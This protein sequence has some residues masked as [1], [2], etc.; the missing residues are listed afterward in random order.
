MRLFFLLVI[1]LSLVFVSDYRNNLDRALPLASQLIDL[2]GLSFSRNFYERRVQFLKSEYSPIKGVSLDT[3]VVLIGDSYI[4]RWPEAIVL[5]NKNVLN[6]GVSAD[7]TLGLLNRLKTKDYRIKTRKVIVLIGFNDLKYRSVNE[8]LS[9]FKV[10]NELLI[11]S[12]NVKS[13]N[14]AYVSVLPVSLNRTYLNEKI[15]DL[16]TVLSAWLS[17]QN[18]DYINLYSIYRN[19]LELQDESYYV[20][21]GIHLSQQGYE[22]LKKNLVGYWE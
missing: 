3:D 19:K 10:L 22:V 9:N 11:L 12:L 7:T 5:Q 4:Q 15:M 8:V 21:D 2:E 13:D 6:L 1:V 14:I 17:T 18:M 16:N 20:D